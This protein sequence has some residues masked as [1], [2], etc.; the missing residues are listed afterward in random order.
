MFYISSHADREA[1]EPFDITALALYTCLD[2]KNV[3]N[4]KILVTENIKNKSS[5]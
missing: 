3:D 5:I 4:L 1:N 2:K